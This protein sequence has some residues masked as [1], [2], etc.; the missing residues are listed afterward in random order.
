[1]GKLRNWKVKS[2]L[3]TLIFPWL[4]SGCCSDAVASLSLLT[5]WWWWSNC[6]SI[7]FTT[8]ESRIV[9]FDNFFTSSFFREVFCTIAIFDFVRIN[10]LSRAHAIIGAQ[11]CENYARKCPNKEAN[12]TTWLVWYERI[13]M[14]VK[15]VSSM[16]F[17]IN[18]SLYLTFFTS[19]RQRNSTKKQPLTQTLHERRLIFTNMKFHIWPD[20]CA[21]NR[22][23]RTSAPKANGME[24]INF[25]VCLA[26]MEHFLDSI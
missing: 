3:Y 25:I 19:T 2:C 24:M 23:E 21:K 4:H 17:I 12:S 18:V 14:I 9:E 20:K 22:R 8:Y 13:F 26:G 5:T 10:S 11:E 15:W 6:T 7:Y 1:M 16:N